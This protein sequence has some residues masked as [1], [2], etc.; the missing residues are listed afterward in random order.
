M[1]DYFAHDLSAEIQTFLEGYAESEGHEYTVD[2]IDNR[3]TGS[4]TLAV[5]VTG[6]HTGRFRVDI[7][8]VD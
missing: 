5:N 2:R 3:Q 4:V 6:P 1:S 7:V 8:P